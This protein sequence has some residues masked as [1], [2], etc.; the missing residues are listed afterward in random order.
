MFNTLSR[1]AFRRPR[2]MS[3]PKL[4]ALFVLA[5]SLGA[6][7]SGTGHER[8][9]DHVHDRPVLVALV[10]YAG[11]TE[12]RSLAATIKPRIESDLGFRVN[13]K[14]A[15]RLVQNGDIVRKGQALLVLDNN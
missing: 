2:A 7:D 10:R 14:V 8:A 4:I 9:E 6:C 13:G 1:A 12:S 5:A 11:L 3:G 15:N